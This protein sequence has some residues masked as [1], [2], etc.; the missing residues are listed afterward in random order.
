MGFFD[1][2]RSQP[3]RRTEDRLVGGVCAGIAHRFGYAPVVIRFVFICLV[4]FSSW[5]LV[6]YGLAWLLLPEHR[7]ER[8]HGEDLLAGRVH[9]AVAGAAILIILGASGR[10]MVNIFPWFLGPI[11][12]P[13][14]VVILAVILT[15]FYATGH[16]R[17]SRESQKNTPAGPLTSAD[18]KPVHLP[19]PPPITH[20]GSKTDTAEAATEGITPPRIQ[21]DRMVDPSGPP[22]HTPGV[23]MTQPPISAT[24]SRP[25][26]VK[27]PAVSSRFIAGSIALALVGATTVLLTGPRTF[28]I[29]LSAA[30]VGTAIIA[31]ALLIAAIRGLRG[32]WLTALSWVLVLPLIAATTIA[33]YTPTSVLADRDAKLLHVGHFGGEGDV[34]A[35]IGVGEVQMDATKTLTLSSAVA[36]WVLHIVP[37]D[38]YRIKITGFGSVSLSAEDGWQVI[39]DGTITSTP[40]RSWT[41]QCWQEPVSPDEEDPSE[42]MRQVCEDFPSPAYQ[43]Y[44]VSAASPLELRTPAAVKN[45]QAAREIT[46]DFGVGSVYLDST[47]PPPADTENSS[48]DPSVTE[49]NPKE[50]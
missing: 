31:G 36:S 5:T 30:G 43:A 46:I 17:R 42:Q 18:G 22:P 45:P 20:S 26:R 32:T 3:Y 6:A 10:G 9:A 23:S 39:S 37:E 7:D 21:P 34:S 15:L 47:N 40:A 38:N 24:N 33:V 25:P 2:L 1:S 29:A 48:A 44:V 27:K 4:L 28:G 8:I 19:S 13:A 49:G 35:I 11:T 50:K 12:L 41:Q 16:R 14:V